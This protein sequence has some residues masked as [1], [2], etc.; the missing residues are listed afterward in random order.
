MQWHQHEPQRFAG[1][2][3]PARLDESRTKAGRTGPNF[4]GVATR[5]A[6]SILKSHAIPLCA[7]EKNRQSHHQAQT[8]QNPEVC[9][10]I[11]T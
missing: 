4:A 7:D 3:L 11:A 10:G 6:G 5:Q 8:A 9:D 2:L 1:E